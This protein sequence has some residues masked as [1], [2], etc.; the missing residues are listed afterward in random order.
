LGHGTPIDVDVVDG[1]LTVSGGLFDPD[2][3]ARMVFADPLEDTAFAP[4]P[5]DLLLTDF[6]GLDIKGIGAGDGL[7]LEVFP[8]PVLDANLAEER[9]LWYWN[10][11][12]EEVEVA[13]NDQMLRVI[14]QRLFGEILLPQTDEPLPLPLQVAEP[15]ENDL[16]QHRHYLYYALPGGSAAAN[17][18][19]GFFARLTSPAAMPSDPFL[20]ALNNGLS[21][22]AFQ[23]GALAINEAAADPSGLPGDYNDNGVVEQADLD[24]VLLNWGADAAAVPEGWVADLPEGFIDQDELDGVLL[25]WG[26]ASTSELAIASVPEPASD[27]VALAGVLAG[28]Y[29]LVRRG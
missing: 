18:T 17:G 2:G 11:V 6:P 3:F 5:G 15:R 8:R 25:N 23:T 10:P 7:I 26:N 13:P 29:A 1:K 12:T 4:A 16:G 9:L 20:I 21:S 19:Y 27:V 14:S 24:L 28:L 22:G